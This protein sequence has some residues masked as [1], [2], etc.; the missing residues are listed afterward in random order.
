MDRIELAPG[1]REGVQVLRDVLNASPETHHGRSGFS[2]SASEWFRVKQDDVFAVG[3][4]GL[5]IT[6]EPTESLLELLAAKRAGEV[7]GNIGKETGE[8]RQ[9]G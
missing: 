7:K 6:L 8:I 2:Q 9:V 4:G 1:V 5:V 3:T